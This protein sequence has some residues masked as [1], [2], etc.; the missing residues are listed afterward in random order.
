M[1]MAINR[2][3]FLKKVFEFFRAEPKPN[4]L[5]V[6]ES[7]L[8]VKYQVDWELFY[9]DIIKE[10][11]KRIL[12]MPKWF[13]DRLKFYRVISQNR[14]ELDNRL[15]QVILINGKVMDFT[16]KAWANTGLYSVVKRFNDNVKEVILYNRGITA[17]DVS[18]GRVSE[19]QKEYLKVVDN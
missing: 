11:E 17:A 8:T 5:S 9:A 2:L 4:L 3:E 16:I 13:V 1:S 19:G 14:S 6:Y 15:L 10:A 7:A 12:P 18:S